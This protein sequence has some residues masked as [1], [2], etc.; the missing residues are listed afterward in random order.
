MRGGTEINVLV[1]HNLAIRNL[2]INNFGLPRY[3]EET[4]LFT[5][6]SMLNQL[7]EIAAYSGIQQLFQ[8]AAPFPPNNG[9]VFLSKYFFQQE[10]RHETM[11]NEKIRTSAYAVNGELELSPF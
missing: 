9:K 7:N 1:C 4:P 5:N 3:L 6:G 11:G 8:N 10:Q 2:Q